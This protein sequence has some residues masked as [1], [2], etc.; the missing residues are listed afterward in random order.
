MFWAVITSS[1]SG[2]VVS[3]V[4]SS[5]DADMSDSCYMLQQFQEGRGFTRM[6]AKHTGSR[7]VLKNS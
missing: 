4:R 7:V 5:V 2:C 1:V 3:T 6:I